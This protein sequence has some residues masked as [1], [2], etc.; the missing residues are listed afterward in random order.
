MSGAPRAARSASSS[1]SRHASALHVSPSRGP[2]RARSPSGSR[3]ASSRTCGRTTRTTV[4]G[5]TS[6]KRPGAFHHPSLRRSAAR[7]RPFTASPLTRAIS[8]RTSAPRP[9]SAGGAAPRPPATARP[10]FCGV[11][12]SRRAAVTSRRRGLLATELLPLSRRSLAPRD[13]AT[14]VLDACLT[15]YAMAVDQLA[16]S[17]AE[18]LRSRSANSDAVAQLLHLPAHR[19]FAERCFVEVRSPLDV[20][21]PLRPDLLRGD[22]RIHHRKGCGYR[23]LEVNVDAICCGAERNAQPLVLRLVDA[24]MHARDDDREIVRRVIADVAPL[25][26]DSRSKPI[27]RDSF[28]RSFLFRPRPAHPAAASCIARAAQP[29]RP[30]RDLPG[31]DARPPRGVTVFAERWDESDAPRPQKR[32]RHFTPSHRLWVCS[33]R[34][35]VSTTHAP[36][37]RLQRVSVSCTRVSRGQAPRR[38]AGGRNV[39]PLRSASAKI[40]AYHFAK[41]SDEAARR[42]SAVTS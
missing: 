13:V 25:L 27:R 40:P 24:G 28:A 31:V 21:V 16:H 33:S 37:R 6:A 30:R 34:P 5:H 26:H 12:P 4:R 8:R 42:G 17:S 3:A 20:A 32:R 22:F 7:E 18:A 36:S 9:P 29:A 14:S 15:E 23:A 39:R 10:R 11:V 2:R 38:R 19:L 1:S 35:H 41:S